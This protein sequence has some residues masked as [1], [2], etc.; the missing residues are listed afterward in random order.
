MKLPFNLF[1]WIEENRDKLRPPVGNQQLYIENSDFIVMIVGGPNN[2]KDF[3]YNEGEEFFF[4][5]QG[6]ITLRIQ[7]DGQLKNIPIK[8]GEIYLLP[9]RVPHSPQRGPNTVGLVIERYRRG[10]EK[11]GVMWFCENCEHKLYEEYFTLTDIVVQLP[12]VMQRFY[13]NEALRTCDQCSTIM[14]PPQPK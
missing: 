6:D 8:E 3:H 12:Q 14:Q 9:P 4:Q 1:T 13:N 2:R 5:L 7:E 10:E 11:D